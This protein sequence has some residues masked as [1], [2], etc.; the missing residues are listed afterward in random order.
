MKTIKWHDLMVL[1]NKCPE[2]IFNVVGACDRYYELSSIDDNFIYSANNY[3][4]FERKFDPVLT[5]T[6][7]LK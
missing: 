5:V 6:I 3:P 7:R 1:F 4:I 2:L